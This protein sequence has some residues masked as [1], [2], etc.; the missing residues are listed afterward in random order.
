[1]ASWRAIESSA[2]D[3][4]AMAKGHFDA[5]LFKVLATL[6]RDGSPRISGVEVEFAEDGELYTGSMWMAVKAQDLRRDP[7]FA[8][9]SCPP[10]SEQWS[11]DAKIAGRMVDVTDPGVTTSHRFRADITE[12]VVVHLDDPREHLLVDAWHESRGVTRTVRD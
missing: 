10:P 3:L 12:L 7:R 5:H 11:G 2:P 9:H 6:R 1:M 4:A 8:L